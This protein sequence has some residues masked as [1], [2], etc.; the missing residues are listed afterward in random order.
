MLSTE[1]STG[2]IMFWIISTEDSAGIINCI[3]VL[4]R[5][6]AIYWRSE[7]GLLT[8]IVKSESMLSAEDIVLAYVLQL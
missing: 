4:E 3:I 7:L 6:Y 2:D 5:K 1:D 8:A